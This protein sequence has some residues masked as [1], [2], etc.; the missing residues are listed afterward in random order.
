VE[1]EKITEYLRG[2][3]EDMLFNMLSFE[4]GRSDNEQDKFYIGNIQI[5]KD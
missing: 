3:P 5:T 2:M 1:K 4:M